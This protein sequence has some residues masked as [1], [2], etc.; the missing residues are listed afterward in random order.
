M[1]HGVVQETTR[2]VRVNGSPAEPCPLRDTPDGERRPRLTFR[3]ADLRGSLPR[4]PG[5]GPG[6]FN[7]TPFGVLL[8]LPVW[9]TL[10]GLPGALLAVPMTASLVLVLEELRRTRPFAVMLSASGRV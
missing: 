1:P 4:T 7:L 6:I 3:R 10:R 9:S 8:A 2:D 5:D